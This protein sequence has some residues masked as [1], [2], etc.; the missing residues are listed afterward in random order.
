[1]CGACQTCELSIRVDR[2]IPS[3]TLGLS[4]AP[5]ALMSIATVSRALCSCDIIREPHTSRPNVESGLNLLRRAPN[6]ITRLGSLDRDRSRASGRTVHS[7]FAYSR[8]SCR[9]RECIALFP[10]RWSAHP[11]GP[12]SCA[13][14]RR[15]EASAIRSCRGRRATL[16]LNRQ[17][18]RRGGYEHRYTRR[19]PPRP[20]RDIMLHRCTF[21]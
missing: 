12:A 1:M 13:P 10:Q 8:R 7:R 11:G 21:P 19:R 18:T 6:S 2:R 15:R 4:L 17:S 3:P 14:Q 9:S 5:A 20:S 16:S